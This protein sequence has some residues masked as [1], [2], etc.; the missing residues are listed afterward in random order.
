MLNT[1]KP[2]YVTSIGGR[3]TERIIT[4]M[5]RKITRLDPARSTAT[6][7]KVCGVL[8]RRRR[9]ITFQALQA[10]ELTSPRL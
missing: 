5:Q 10:G 7:S 8:S 6:T 3:V 4:G 2:N 9:A 1:H